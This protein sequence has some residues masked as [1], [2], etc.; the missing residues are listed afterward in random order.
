MTSAASFNALDALC[1]PSAAT[2]WSYQ[3]Y[4]QFTS[5]SYGSDAFAGEVLYLSAQNYL[6][7][8]VFEAFV[9]QQYRRHS[10]LNWS[11]FTSIESAHKS[12]W[13]KLLYIG[14]VMLSNL[15]IKHKYGQ[16]CWRKLLIGKRYITDL[17]LEREQIKYFTTVACFCPLNVGKGLSLSLNVLSLE[18]KP[19]PLFK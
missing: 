17:S 3:N 7:K 9:W 19:R 12:L 2:T 13:K 6:R 18:S 15:Y 1:S 4:T 14:S 11:A 10:C 8:A 16:L 5:L